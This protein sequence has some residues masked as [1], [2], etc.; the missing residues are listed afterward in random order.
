MKNKP[1]F[2]RIDVED[3]INMSPTTYE[4]YFPDYSDPEGRRESA[5]KDTIILLE[6]VS[7]K[8]SEAEGDMPAIVWF[9]RAMNLSNRLRT[10]GF[11]NEALQLCTLGH[12][13]VQKL[14]SQNSAF[15]RSDLASSFDNMS[16][17]LSAMGNKVV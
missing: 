8:S 4:T 5:V 14:A 3:M 16:V 1:E 7:G 15:F 12:D 2:S 17:L 13:V 10:L 9:N 6:I 11:R